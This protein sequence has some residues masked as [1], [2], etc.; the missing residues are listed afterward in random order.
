MK[1]SDREK[2]YN[3]YGGRCAYCGKELEKGW[4][5]DHI[6]PIVRDLRNKSKCEFPEREVIENYN[7]SCPSCNRLKS[8]MSI[9]Q[10]RNNIAKMVDS[11]NNYSV[12]YQVCKRYG[13]VEETNCKVVFYFENPFAR[14]FLLDSMDIEEIDCDFSD[15][16]HRE[17]VRKICNLKY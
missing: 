1:K 6:K 7:P 5:V 4:H 10:F 3:K 11:L 12:Q 9:E 17:N 8:S 14:R 15:E 16:Q 13:L 2:I